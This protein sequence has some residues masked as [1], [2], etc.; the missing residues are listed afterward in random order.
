MAFVSFVSSGDSF[1]FYVISVVTLKKYIVWKILEMSLD[2]KEH[3]LLYITVNENMH[4]C[5]LVIN[6]KQCS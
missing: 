2:Q 6:I 1:D 3:L 5:Q 4:C